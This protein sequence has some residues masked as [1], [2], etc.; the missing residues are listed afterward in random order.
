MT[1]EYVEDNSA[2]K[3]II[4]NAADISIGT[5]YAKGSTDG[6]TTWA[7][8]KVSALGIVSVILTAGSAA[9]GSLT[10]GTA[11]I[12]KVGIDQ[13]TAGTTNA[14]ANKGSSDGGTTWYPVKVSAAGVQAVDPATLGQALAAASMPVVLASDVNVSTVPGGTAVSGAHNAATAQ[15][16]HELIADP[17]SSKTIYVQ[18]LAICNAGTAALTIQLETD[19]AGAKTA[20]GPVFT[21]PTGIAG[22]INLAFGPGL[23]CT[24]HKNL[25]YTSTGSTAFSVSVGGTVR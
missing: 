17:G 19:T 11:I 9:I 25:G 10:A 24:V 21:M 15:T 20:V 2:P 22:A 8:I 18:T 3:V 13:T 7:P 4:A 23:A 16:D 6:G 1:N 5:V 14:V 12:G